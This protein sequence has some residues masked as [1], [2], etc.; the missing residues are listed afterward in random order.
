M[1]GIMEMDGERYNLLLLNLLVLGAV[2]LS[3]GAFPS[4]FRN[5]CDRRVYGRLDCKKYVGFP[6]RVLWVSCSLGGSSLRML[7]C[8]GLSG[9]LGELDA[10]VDPIGSVQFTLSRSVS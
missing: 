8:V 9:S 1:F 4:N 7:R 5:C 10:L 3:I 2:V 6:Y